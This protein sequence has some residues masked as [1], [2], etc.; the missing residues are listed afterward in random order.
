MH[1]CFRLLNKIA[2]SR[3]RNERHARV[4]C[5]KTGVG[6]MRS[7]SPENATIRAASI[8]PFAAVT[9]KSGRCTLAHSPASAQ[10]R[11]KHPSRIRSRSDPEHAAAP[12]PD[13]AALRGHR[14]GEGE[15]SRQEDRMI[16]KTWRYFDR[17]Q[18]LAVRAEEVESTM[19]FAVRW[20]RLAVVKPAS[21]RPSRTDFTEG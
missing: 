16:P 10:R 17:G 8:T 20:V 12:H 1:S 19:S 6:R 5:N 14:F 11:A 7:E 18:G 15:G 4:G 21:P 9:K 2:S 13:D 3:S